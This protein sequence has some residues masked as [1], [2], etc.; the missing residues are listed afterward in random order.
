MGILFDY[1]AGLNAVLG[2]LLG[3]SCFSFAM[4]L[5]WFNILQRTR[6]SY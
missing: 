6:I 5:L 1:G 3:L 2:L 4:P